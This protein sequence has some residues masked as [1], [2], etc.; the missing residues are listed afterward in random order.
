[1]AVCVHRFLFALHLLPDRLSTVHA[2]GV[3]FYAHS[4]R[5]KI[6]EINLILEYVIPLVSRHLDLAETH[7]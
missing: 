1:V 6:A 4:I 3:K 2:V 7:I 5:V